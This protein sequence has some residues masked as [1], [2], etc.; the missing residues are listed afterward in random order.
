MTH[1]E[2]RLVLRANKLFAAI[3]RLRHA[4]NPDNLPLRQR[5]ALAAY[6]TEV[7]RWNALVQM[8]HA[9]PPAPGVRNGPCPPPLPQYASQASQVPHEA[10]SHPS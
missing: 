10:V 9:R 6:A 5:Q 8:L 2:R 4:E 1:A 3:H 7:K